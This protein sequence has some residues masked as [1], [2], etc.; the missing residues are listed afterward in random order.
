M[1]PGEGETLSERRN[2][3][4][5]VCMRMP[6][7]SWG[8]NVRLGVGISRGV[9]ARN[10]H[11][12]ALR[13]STC[14]LTETAYPRS[15]SALRQ[16][17]PESNSTQVAPLLAQNGSFSATS[18]F[19][20]RRLAQ[21]PKR[22]ALHV[23]SSFS[24][25]WAHRR[26]QLCRSSGCL[27]SSGRWMGLSKELSNKDSSRGPLGAAPSDDPLGDHFCRRKRNYPGT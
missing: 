7:V 26:K 20:F 10:S 27:L 19:C 23:H 12:Q 8:P 9:V 21:P 17:D 6:A 16:S 24:I 13:K 4:C 2:S 11:P 3:D 22:C 15:K 25:C 18:P 14:R 5:G 1:S